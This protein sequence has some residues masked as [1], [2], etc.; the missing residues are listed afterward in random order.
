MCLEKRVV[1]GQNH[2]IPFKTYKSILISAKRHRCLFLD[3]ILI[4][5]W[6]RIRRKAGT[7][8]VQNKNLLM[9]ITRFNG[10]VGW[11]QQVRSRIACDRPAGGFENI[12]IHSMEDFNTVVR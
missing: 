2:P 3:R 10:Y 5:L 6:E 8:T 1:F 7:G 4:I 11:P 9:G 12:T